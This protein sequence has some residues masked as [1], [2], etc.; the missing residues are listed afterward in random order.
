MRAP[1]PDATLQGIRLYVEAGVP[2]G[3]FLMAV[4]QNDLKEAFGRADEYNTRAMHSIVQ[5]L[6]NHVPEVC[7]GSPEKVKQWLTMHQTH[8]EKAETKGS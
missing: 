3:D 8:R 4:L 6:Y 5:Y 1:I 2:P 7:W